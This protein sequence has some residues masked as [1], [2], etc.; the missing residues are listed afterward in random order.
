MSID[1]FGGSG[2]T[3][4]MSPAQLK[5]LIRTWLMDDGWSLRQDTPKDSIWVF[6]ADDG[7]GRRVVIGQR[8]GKE[9]QILLQGA[10]TI[11][12][13]TS[14]KIDQMP[15]EEKNDLLWDLR[16]E[17]LRTS[18]EFSG[19]E[20]PLKQVGVTGRIIADSLSKDYFFNKVSEV[21][22]GVLI[23]VWMLQRR[24]AEQPPAKQMGFQR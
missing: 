15:N 11:D 19:L 24:F 3:Y 5:D 1:I 6:I 2:M 17:L 23:I 21:R 8:D 20:L 14:K 16:F 10:V 9:D 7:R 18:L 4:E 22:K 13:A 12:D